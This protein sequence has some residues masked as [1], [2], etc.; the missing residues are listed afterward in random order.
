MA[1]VLP[2][3]VV[4]GKGQ[5]DGEDGVG[6]AGLAVHVG[7]GDRSRLVALHDK[8]VDLLGRHDEELGEAL[9]VRAQDVVLANLSRQKSGQKPSF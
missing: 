2:E 4:D 9:H 7:G 8:I 3:R 5:P 1:L 6:S